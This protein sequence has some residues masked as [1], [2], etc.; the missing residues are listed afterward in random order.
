MAYKNQKTGHPKIYHP[1]FPLVI[2]L[3]NN[4]FKEDQ[5]ADDGNEQHAAHG[6]AHD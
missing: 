6:S 1:F 3:E 2:L 4:F 5:G